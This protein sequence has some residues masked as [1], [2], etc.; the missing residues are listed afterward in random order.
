M[1]LKYEY[2]VEPQFK[3]SF[4]SKRFSYKSGLKSHHRLIHKSIKHYEFCFKNKK[5]VIITSNDLKLKCYNYN[6]LIPTN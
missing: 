4:C 6:F 1:H 3:C 5:H 2:G